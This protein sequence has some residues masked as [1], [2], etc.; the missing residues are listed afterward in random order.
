MIRTLKAA[1]RDRL[2]RI[3]KLR[4]AGGVPVTGAMSPGKYYSTSR[5]KRQIVT[6]LFFSVSRG[7]NLFSR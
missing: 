3:E 2:T 1:L 5:S 4:C 6:T 7:P